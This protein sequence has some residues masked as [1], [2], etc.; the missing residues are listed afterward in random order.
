[1]AVV[2]HYE[3]YVIRQEEKSW[4]ELLRNMEARPWRPWRSAAYLTFP[5]TLLSG[6]RTTCPRVIL[7]LMGWALA[8]QS[9]IKKRAHCLA[10][11]PVWCGY[12]LSWGFLLPNDSNLDQSE[13]KQT[14]KQLKEIYLNM[15]LI[16]SCFKYKMS[17]LSSC[18]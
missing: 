12:F 10:S 7:V 4:Q 6:F 3:T 17:P 18:I 9:L 8:H 1:M 13:K 2:K 16:L 5:Q 14:H 15:L 11:Q